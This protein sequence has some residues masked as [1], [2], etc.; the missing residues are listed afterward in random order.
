MT[1][2]LSLLISESPSAEGLPSEKDL[3]SLC[4]YINETKSIHN[5]QMMT[6]RKCVFEKLIFSG[7]RMLFEASSDA[8]VRISTFLMDGIRTTETE[9]QWFHIADKHGSKSS[10]HE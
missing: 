10:L 6:E 1:Y 2:L 3:N 5:V 9:C 8:Y 7:E 4:Y